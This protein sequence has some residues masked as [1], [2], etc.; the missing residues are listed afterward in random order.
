MIAAA[1]VM[2]YCEGRKTSPYT[3]ILNVIHVLLTLMRFGTHGV[4]HEI[5]KMS[6]LKLLKG[7]CSFIVSH[8]QT[9]SNRG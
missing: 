7:V 8:E 6:H 2:C 5:C 9:Q 3:S 1:F 4:I